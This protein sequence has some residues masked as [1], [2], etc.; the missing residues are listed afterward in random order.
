LSFERARVVASRR[1]APAV[2]NL[3]LHVPSLAGSAAPPAGE[4][5]LRLA[6]ADG[7]TDERR[8]SV[9]R[10]D[11]TAATLDVCV[12]LHGLGPGSR[13]AAGCAGGEP[14]EV[15]V[16]KAPPFPLVPFA[17]EHL[18]LGD[19]TSVAGADALMRALPEDAARRACFEV[20]SDET[21]WPGDALAD[22]GVVTWILR[23]GRPGAALSAWLGGFRAKEGC[24]AYVTGEA[25]LCAAVQTR[26]VKEC[27]VAPAAVRALP[28]WRRRP[29][30]P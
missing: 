27:G 16:P 3:T 25:W 13:W 10:S 20:G 26:L 28:F 11:G 1:L 29:A 17:S 18:F 5:V 9:W 6:N 14:L 19:E 4:V 24:A 21:R 22:A 2:A 12:V 23:Q 15:S 7:R 8:Y 30:V